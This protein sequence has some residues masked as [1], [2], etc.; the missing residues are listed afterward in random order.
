[1]TIGAAGPFSRIG[2]EPAFG[3]GEAGEEHPL[4]ACAH[5]RV[6]AG[7]DSTPP[8][9]ATRGGLEMRTAPE[10]A[11]ALCYVPHAYEERDRSLAHVT[12]GAALL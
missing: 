12:H 5:I 3:L 8:L 9:G 4:G 10:G 11:A 1:M 6:T 7:K 2:Q